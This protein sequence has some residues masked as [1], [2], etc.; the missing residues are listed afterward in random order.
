M[1]RAFKT[2]NASPDKY[3]DLMVDKAK[4]PD[5]LRATL[6]VPKFP[7]AQL[8]TREDVE[9]VTRWMVEKGYAGTDNTVR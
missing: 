9:D 7:D 8:P 6:A 2:L 1:R 3:R 5:A 4:V